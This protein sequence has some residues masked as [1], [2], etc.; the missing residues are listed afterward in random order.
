M[1]VYHMCAWYQLLRQFFVCLG[2]SHLLLASYLDLLILLSP[3]S[4]N[5][6]YR[7]PLSYI[8]YVVLRVAGYLITL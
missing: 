7:C 5:Q 8:V 6:G 4:E 2:Q 3:A 1:F